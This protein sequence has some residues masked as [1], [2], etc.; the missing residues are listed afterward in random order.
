MYIFELMSKLK[1]TDKRIGNQFWQLA[2]PDKI[3]QPPKYKPDTLIQKA[4]EYFE[5]VDNNPIE[6]EQNLG[7]KNVN[8][9]KLRQPYTLKG[10]WLFANICH[11][12]WQNYRKKN[13]YVAVVRKIEDIIYN[14]KYI[15]ATIGIFKENIIARDLGLA[16]KK[17]VDF[18][19][20]NI[21]V[22]I[23]PRKT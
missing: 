4:I 18:S 23:K 13:E 12:T 11:T 1:K 19:T 17:D 15:G 5:W 22:K 16:D 9:V 3:G 6:V 21:E 7:T 14:H 2:D 10:F 8:K 20:K